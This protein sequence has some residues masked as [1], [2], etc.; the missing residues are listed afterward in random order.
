MAALTSSN[1]GA[2][3][4]GRL[5]LMKHE[6][7]RPILLLAQAVLFAVSGQ[8]AVAESVVYRFEAEF[9]AVHVP[10]PAGSTTARAASARTLTGTFGYDRDV[11][12]SSAAGI[13][14]RVAFADYATGVIS[15]DQLDIGTLPGQ[16]VT[17][18]T[19][20]RGGPEDPAPG[21]DDAVTI[22]HRA[23]STASAIDSVTLELRYKNA[24]A[25]GGSPCRRR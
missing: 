24:G 14:G 5:G 3:R 16:V 20:G 23:V 15:V 13:P 21:I 6:A 7:S 25:L 12:Q 17:Q 2:R 18:V 4:R 1:S 22:G 11:R 9:G 10:P 8:A 19:D